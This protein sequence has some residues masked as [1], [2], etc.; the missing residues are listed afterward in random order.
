MSLR[1]AA[2]VAAGC[3]TALA[4]ALGTL[5]CGLRVAPAAVPTSLLKRFERKVRIEIAERRG[6]PNETQ[7]YVLERDDGGPPLQLFLPNMRVSFDFED[8]GES[9]EMQMDGLGFCN[10]TE[11]DFRREEIQ[12]IAIGDS[13]TVC[14][15]PKPGVAWPSQLGRKT[16]MTAYNLGRGGVGPYE[17]VQILKRFGLAKHPDVVVL[18]IYEGN[19]LRDS[20]FHQRFRAASPRE[21]A[22]F[23]ER[24]SLASYSVDP[25]SW[26]ANPLGRNSYAYNLALVGAARGLSKLKDGLSG[27]R[28]S[29]VDFRYRLRFPDGAVEMNVRNT[30]RDEV[31]TAL[32]VRAG[33]ISF[34]AMDGAIDAFAELAARHGFVP[35]VSY[36]P[37]AHS[38]Y[39]EIVEFADPALAELLAAFSEAQRQ[40]LQARTAARGVHFLDLTPAMR[41]AAR[42]GGAARLLYFPINIHFTPEGHELVASI[43]AEELA[44]LGTLRASAN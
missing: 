13:F 36:A 5:E 27:E 26:L 3:I 1:R 37:S 15:P 8:T 9:G 10:A 44:R 34:D 30:D 32:E 40:H 41:S 24:A 21:R 7:T 43:V 17:Y 18:Q 29:N 2:G 12:L 23:P 38:A 14:H 6:L 4:L 33:T 22:S 16:G 28:K 31:Q 25:A 42:E 39:A 35:V 11:D 20:I 19:D